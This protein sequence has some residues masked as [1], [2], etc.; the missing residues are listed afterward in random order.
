M[1]EEKDRESQRARQIEGKCQVKLMT[2]NRKRGGE[3]EEGERG[4]EREDGVG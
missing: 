2:G 3:R 1:E 4:G